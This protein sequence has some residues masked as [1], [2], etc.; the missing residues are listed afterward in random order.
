MKNEDFRMKNDGRE[1]SRT[2]FNRRRRRS[3]ILRST[4]YILHFGGTS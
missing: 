2:S 1:V 3:G 4:F